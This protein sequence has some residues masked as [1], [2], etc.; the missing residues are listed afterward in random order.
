MPVL[1]VVKKG[2]ERSYSSVKKPSLKL[3]CRDKLFVKG[4]QL[5]CSK[6]IIYSMPNVVV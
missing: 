4:K 3:Q 1:V 5:F 6:F 2:L